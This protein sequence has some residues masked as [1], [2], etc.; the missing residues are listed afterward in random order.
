MK[1][2]SLIAMAAAMLLTVSTAGITAIVSKED[3]KAAKEQIST[4]YGADKTDCKLK[5]GNTRDI[6]MQEARSGEKIA[7]AELEQSYAPSAK[8]RYDVRITRVESAYAVAK[9]KCDDFAGNAKNVCRKEAKSAFVAGEAD[10]KLAEKTADA[11]STA[12][13]KTSVARKSAATDK[14]VAAYAVVRE[15]CDAFADDV[16]ANCI[17]D[18]KLRFEQH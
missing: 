18:A 3:Y 4:K 6:C 16:R 7:K 2:K 5:S 1:N 14:R 11:H 8:H 17:K 12:R 15:K 9:E 13:E 10:A